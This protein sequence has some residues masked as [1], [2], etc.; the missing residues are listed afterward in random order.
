ML[1]NSALKRR[2]EHAYT[3]DYLRIMGVEHYRLGYFTPDLA[4]DDLPAALE[5]YL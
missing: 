4:P 5:R 3:D 2:M 1:D